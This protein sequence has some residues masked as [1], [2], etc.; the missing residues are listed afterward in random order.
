MKQQF[1]HAVQGVSPEHTRSAIAK[2]VQQRD[3]TMVEKQHPA[4]VLRPYGMH[5]S[6]VDRQSHKQQMRQDHQQAQRRN[7]RAQ[8][9]YQ[10]EA[11][12][13]LSPTPI[14]QGIGLS[15]RFNIEAAQAHD[16]KTLGLT[17]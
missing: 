7:A 4:P 9:I 12:D 1:T 17:R 15:H 16:M 10:R 6:E 2:G 14:A 13:L 3:K 8:S 11:E 5:A